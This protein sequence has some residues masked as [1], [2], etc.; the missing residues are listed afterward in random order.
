MTFEYLKNKNK[1]ITCI[2]CYNS[3][4]SEEHSKYC[5]TVIMCSR[6]EI[7]IKDFHKTLMTY[8][9][10]GCTGIIIYNK[11]K[12]TIFM[13]HHPFKDV[14]NEWI[15]EYKFDDVIIYLKIYIEYEKIEDNQYYTEKTPT[16]YKI[17]ESFKNIKFIIETYNN[18][19]NYSCDSTLYCKKNENNEICYSKWGIWKLLK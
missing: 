2:S 16:F 7:P 4:N 17:F 19:S 3:I 5:N 6:K 13:G 18:T 10:G 12:N 15:N 11:T 9:L 14:I 1:G 8:G